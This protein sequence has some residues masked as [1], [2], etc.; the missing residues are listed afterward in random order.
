LSRDNGRRQSAIPSWGCLVFEP[1]IRF[2]PSG[3]SYASGRKISGTY[4]CSE[5]PPNL[6]PRHR[7]ASI[8]PVNTLLGVDISENKQR[9]NVDTQEGVN[10]LL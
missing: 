8:T 7:E 1:A 5:T 2:T 9:A 10:L 6:K 4:N 3:M